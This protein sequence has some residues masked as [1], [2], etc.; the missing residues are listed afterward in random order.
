MGGCASLAC[1]RELPSGRRRLPSSGHDFTPFAGARQPLRE[2]GIRLYAAAAR[3]GRAWSGFPRLEGPRASLAGHEP[4]SVVS[5]RT[6]VEARERP[7]SAA[8]VA[9]ASEADGNLETGG[10]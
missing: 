2:R 3:H 7:R 10:L 1:L 5:T 6:R 4:I 9:I 8:S